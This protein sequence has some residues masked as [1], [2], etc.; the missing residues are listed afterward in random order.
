MDHRFPTRCDTGEID[1]TVV[2]G[3]EMRSHVAHVRRSFGRRRLFRG[4]TLSGGPELEEGPR[5]AGRPS[6]GHA[7]DGHPSLCKDLSCRS[8]R[9]SQE[10]TRPCLKAGLLELQ[11]QDDV[12]KLTLSRNTFL[13][14]LCFLPFEI[15]VCC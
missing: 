7:P 1:E 12:T 9:A 14:T 3:L 8:L 11:T 15:Q 10:G 13:V 2:E 5:A 4:R 6:P